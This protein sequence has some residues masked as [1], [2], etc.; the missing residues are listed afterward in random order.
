M[1]PN[2]TAAATTMSA[3]AARRAKNHRADLFDVKTPTPYEIM[4]RRAKSH[5]GF[6]I[7]MSDRKSTRLN[8]QSH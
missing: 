6:L 2:D 8:S 5:T 3:G 4:R 1:A 7:G